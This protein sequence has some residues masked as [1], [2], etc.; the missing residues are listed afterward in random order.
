MSG[1]VSVSA[2]LRQPTTL[3]VQSPDA[4][5]EID[6][7]G[8]ISG[9]NPAA[10]AMFG[11]SRAEILYG[12][13]RR[14]VPPVCLPQLERVWAA[15]AAG[16]SVP[17]FETVRLHRSGAL[18]PVSLHVAAITD[19]GAFAG[20]VAT[21]RDLVTAVRTAKETGRD[22]AVWFDT[23]HDLQRGI[24]RGELRLH[25]Q[26]I[27]ELTFNK[28]VGVEALVRWERPGVGLLQPADFI[29]LAERTGQIVPLGA[30]VAQEAC[31]IAVE[32]AR[33]DTGPH[34]VSIN[35][36]ARQL[37]DPG[38]VEMLRA[39]LLDSS[40]PPSSIDIEVTETALMHDMGAA[41]ATL[42]AI[43][44]LG[45]SLAL[46]DFG[47]GYSSLLYLRHFPV[48]RIKIDQ[49]FVQGLGT[50]AD[51]TAI[52]AST[53]SLAHSI[54]VRCVAEGVETAGQL[55]LLRQLGC[56]FAQGYLFSRPLTLEQLHLWLP[57][58]APSSRPEETDRILH[59]H[60]EGASLNT[61]AAALNVQGLRTAR[62]SRWTAP[63]VA[64]VILPR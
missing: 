4:V 42:D 55:A 60:A 29:G 34:A 30:W 16:E 6:L 12:P 18:K 25:F 1:P 8:R 48:D 63:T 58:H 57:G 46:D 10:E 52:V 47:T 64:K 17:V 23:S 54:G 39:A 61:I 7:E 26:P 22:R 38:V 13:V 43:K 9:W 53:I 40:C 32:L 45:V 14:V 50:N 24:E 62:G 44:A 59:L 3:L 20:A 35:L 2:Q 33:L 19:H 36:S 5:L 21:C 49:S 15:L 27:I 51:D 37:S 28:L 31:R 11:W 56:D 41:T